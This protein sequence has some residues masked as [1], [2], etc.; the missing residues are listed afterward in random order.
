MSGALTV[1]A[2]SRL[3][4]DTI[5]LG[6]PS[7]ASTPYHPGISKPGSVSAMGDTPGASGVGRSVDN[8]VVCNRTEN[9][10]RFPVPR[11]VRLPVRY[12]TEPRLALLAAAHLR[13]TYQPDAIH[14]HFGWSGLRMLLLKQYLRIPMVVTFGGRDL[15]VQMPM[16]EFRELIQVNGQF[17]AVFMY[18]QAV[19]AVFLA[20]LA[21]PGLI[22]PDLANNA[23]PLYFSRPLSR[24][25]YM[26]AR[27]LV[28][29]GVLSPITWIPGVLLFL[30]QS[31]LGGWLWFAAN[32]HIGAGIFI[33][34]LL[35]IL[36][37]SLVAM[38]SSACVRWRMVAGGLVLGVFFV[39]A[40]ASEMAHM[41]L[42]VEWVLAMNPGRNM[43]QI[44]R[45]QGPLTVDRAIPILSQ[46]CGALQEAHEL[47]MVHR[48]LKPE[49]IF[50]TTSGGMKDFAKVL[51]FGLAKVTE[52][53]LRPGS[54]MLTQEGMVFGTPEF[55]SPEQAQGLTL[56]R[57]SDIYSLA[58]ILYEALTCRTPFEQASANERCARCTDGQL[59]C[60]GS[61]PRQCASKFEACHIGARS[62]Q[63]T[64]RGTEQH[65]QQAALLEIEH[66]QPRLVGG[67]RVVD[68]RERRG[69]VNQPVLDRVGLRVERE[70]EHDGIERR[71]G[72]AER[73]LE[74]I[75][76]G[77]GQQHG[78]T[79]ERRGRGG[80]VR[81]QA[82]AGPFT[83]IRGCERDSRA[84]QDEGEEHT[85]DL[86]SDGHVGHGRSHGT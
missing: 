27:L 3:I 41:I 51:D 4:L 9:L 64:D 2:N 25:E 67:P 86:T 15:G 61:G 66:E 5:G 35:W 57:R 85:Q 45:R 34:F 28:L 36:L 75:V 77:P 81:R 10:D 65:K 7:G 68:H 29:L 22:A 73:G 74:R 53:E 32:W 39:L 44:V 1:L 19:F 71:R 12:V 40:G 69:I 62:Q 49:N 18:V 8:V 52:R 70:V 6:T 54:I 48:D 17:F 16:P 14:A 33:G 60:I 83:C 80:D 37:V 50:I 46:V 20:A 82:G 63:E 43:N 30:M 58:I 56:D 11:L 13:R 21:G 72:E 76:L 23:L 59:D 79:R 38:A 31:A 42:N 24:A 84:R 47:G 55:M 26:L 78:L